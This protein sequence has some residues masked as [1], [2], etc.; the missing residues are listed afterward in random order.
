MFRVILEVKGIIRVFLGY[1][2]VKVGVRV[3]WEDLEWRGKSKF[4]DGR[5]GRVRRSLEVKY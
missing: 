2:D 1:W 5:D 4:F 3:K